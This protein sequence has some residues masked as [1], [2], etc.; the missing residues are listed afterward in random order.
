MAAS[1]VSGTRRQIRELVD[2]TIRV[3]IDLDPDCRE[4]FLRLFPN[5][6]ARVALAP[7]LSE[8]QQ[9]Q[10]AT[11]LGPMAQLACVWCRDPVFRKWLFVEHGEEHSF[12]DNEETAAGLLKVVCGIESRKELDTNEEAKQRFQTLIRYPFMDFKG[13]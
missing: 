9:H 11:R 2:G 7:L 12:S 5:I 13:Q 8:H 3:Q 4:D 1:A 6:D 10:Q